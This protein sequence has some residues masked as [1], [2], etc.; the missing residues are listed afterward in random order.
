M[1]RTYRPGARGATEVMASDGPEALEGAVWIDIA[2]PLAYEGPLLQ[3][4]TGIELPTRADM[5]EIE[6]SSRIYREGGASFITVLLVVGLD[7]DSPASVPVS[8]ILTPERLVTVRYSD[9]H[10][11]RSFSTTCGRQGVPDSPM[12][13]LIGILDAIVDRTA[14]ILERMASDIDKVSGTV[15]ALRTPSGKRLSTDDLTDILR[16]I[17]QINLV[18]N[19]AHDSIQ[20]LMRMAGY[21]AIPARAAELKTEK[22]LREELKSVLRDLQSIDQNAGYLSSNVSFLLDAALGRISIEQ[23]AIIKIFSVGAVVF[24]PPTLVASIYGMNFEIMPELQWNLGYP[25]AL[26]LMVLSAIIPYLWFKR[27]GWL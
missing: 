23:N 3:A 19:K 6:A 14:D 17:G 20:T 4:A 22:P 11:F 5:V 21:L 15:F 13:V 16:R 1:I 7:S 10:P 9:P 27:K 26:G 12:K 25:F 24:L 8:F 2:D 18:L